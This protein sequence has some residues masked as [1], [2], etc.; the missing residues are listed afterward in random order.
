MGRGLNGEGSNTAPGLPGRVLWGRAASPARCRHL[1]P[2]PA[3][4]RLVVALPFFT[5]CSLSSTVL[6]T[7]RRIL[8]QRWGREAGSRRS[9]TADS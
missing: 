1:F 5:K 4:E 2:V 9:G 6:G 7:R 8:G 3:K